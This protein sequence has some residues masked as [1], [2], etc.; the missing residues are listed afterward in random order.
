MTKN[1]SILTAIKLA[2]PYLLLQENGKV[3]LISTQV[4]VQIDGVIADVTVNQIYVNEDEKKL[5]AVYVFAGSTRAAVYAME[6]RIGDRIIEAKVKEKQAARKEFEEARQQGKTAG[7]LEQHRPNVFQMEVTNIMTGDKVEVAMRYTE[8]VEYRDAIYEFVYPGAVGPRYSKGDEEWV[9]MAVEQLID[10][11]PDF[12]MKISILSPVPV[13]SISSASHPISVDRPN[14]KQ[15]LVSLANPLDKQGNGD[16]I[17]RYGLQGKT[18]QSGMLTYGHPDG[19]QFFMLMVQPPAKPPIETI[20]PREY[21]FI[22]DVSGSMH[23]FPLDVAK[24]TLKNLISSLRPTD[25]FNVILF[26]FSAGILS[27]KSLPATK[28]NIQKA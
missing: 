25:L 11:Q 1:P 24:Q 7:L 26:S 8:T 14:E 10:I 27:D 28:E 21:I 16:F 19:E 18:V 4:N 22:V 23:G 12:D 15:V 20:P 2:S 17:L 3:R 13:Q 6:I 9:E 5:D